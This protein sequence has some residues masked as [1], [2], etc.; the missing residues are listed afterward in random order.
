[1][2][3]MI[4]FAAVFMWLFSGGWA[5]VYLSPDTHKEHIG[6]LVMLCIALAPFMAGLAAAEARRKTKSLIRS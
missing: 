4:G 3:V 2:K 5:L 1:M 6:G